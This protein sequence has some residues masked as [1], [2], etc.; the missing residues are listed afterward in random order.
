M[1]HT[2]FLIPLILVI[3]IVFV[4]ETYIFMPINEKPI[5][6]TDQTSDTTGGIFQL[7]IEF[8]SKFK[9]EELNKKRTGFFQGLI[10]K[11]I[12]KSS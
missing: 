3:F 2:N 7:V 6:T 4:A 12:Y 1:Y 11:I 5:K 10:S 9:C 8:F